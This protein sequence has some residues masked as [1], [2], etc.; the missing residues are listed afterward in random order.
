MHLAIGTI[1]RVHVDRRVIAQNRKDGGNR[2]AMT[3]QTSRGPVKARRVV[4]HGTLV[5]DQRAKQ[6]SCGARIYGET[7]AAVDAT[8]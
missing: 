7:R 8:L 5:F 3:V 6:L 4:I 1:K 2:P